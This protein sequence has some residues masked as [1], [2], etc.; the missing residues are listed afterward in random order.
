MNMEASRP[1]ETSES[2]TRYDPQNIWK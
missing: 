2:T 1:S